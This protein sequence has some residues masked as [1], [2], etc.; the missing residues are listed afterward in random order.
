M[1]SL[2]DELSELSKIKLSQEEKKILSK[3]I[4]EILQYFQKILSLKIEEEEKINEFSEE[5][6]E[7]IVEASNKNVLMTYKEKDGENRVIVPKTTL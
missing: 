3:D 5:L 6:K 4:D 7:D 2:I 1:T